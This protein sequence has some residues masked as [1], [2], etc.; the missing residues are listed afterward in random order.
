MNL[1]DFRVICAILSPGK[2]SAMLGKD[3]SYIAQVLKGRIGWSEKLEARLSDLLEN[4]G[5]ASRPYRRVELPFSIEA[6]YDPQDQ[7]IGARLSLSARETIVFSCATQSFG[8]GVGFNPE[9]FG[10]IKYVALKTEV[11]DA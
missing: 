6:A 11:E 9:H 3:P 8:Q 2:L 1:E 10:E 7:I 5:V 4:F